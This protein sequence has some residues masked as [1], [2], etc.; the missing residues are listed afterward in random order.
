M[1]W[2]TWKTPDGKLDMPALLDAFLQW[3]RENS[4]V[5]YETEQAPFREAAAYLALMGFL[6]KVVNGG[7]R[8]NREYAAARGR[9][10]LVVEYAGERFVL[11]LKRIPPEHRTAAAV[12]AEGVTQL[13]GYL[14]TLGMDEGWLIL[15][16]QRKGRS[17]K[18]RLWR[19]EVLVGHRRLHLIGA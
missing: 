15:F 2:W 18:K 10:D 9:V 13:A 7:G 12:E 14:D 19:K 17:W 1:P 11:E 16:D 5:L 4:E 8:V 6:Q 3:W